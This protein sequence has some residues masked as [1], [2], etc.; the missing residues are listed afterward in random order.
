MAAFV[1]VLSMLGLNVNALLLPAGVALAYAAKDLSHNFLAGASLF[2]HSCAPRNY[3]W[4]EGNAK[5]EVSGHK[6]V[7]G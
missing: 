6:S 7:L 1:I 4:L 3:D 2:I 5:L